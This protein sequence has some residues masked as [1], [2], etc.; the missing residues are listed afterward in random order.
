[1]KSRFA[2]LAVG[3]APP[4]P[5]SEFCV[6]FRARLS[7]LK[8][9]IPGAFAASIMGSDG[10]PIDAIETPL[11]GVDTSGLI[12]EYGALLESVRKTAQMFAAGRLEEVAVRSEH[13]TALLRPINDEFFLALVLGPEASLGKS[14]YLLRI[15]APQLEEALS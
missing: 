3:P 5:T 14:R 13:L 4:A 8:E 15:E 6:D 10:I 2:E 11:K 1:M 12:V 7:R 9:A